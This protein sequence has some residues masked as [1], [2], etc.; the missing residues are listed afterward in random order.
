MREHIWAVAARARISRQ[1]GL[2]FVG[3]RAVLL[4]EPCGTLDED[5][6]AT[7]RGR[8]EG[9]AGWIVGT[10]WAGL[11][12][13]CWGVGELVWLGVGVDVHIL[14]RQL[15]PD[16]EQ[17]SGFVLI[18][19]PMQQL[20]LRRRHHGRPNAPNSPNEFQQA[21]RESGMT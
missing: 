12:W 18:L 15:C 3:V 7:R 5:D 9:D 4:S 14:R 16:G 6:R 20:L 10:V 2:T 13:L 1:L 17:A 11:G 8:V 19:I 21:V